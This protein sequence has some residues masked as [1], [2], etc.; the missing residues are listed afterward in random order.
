MTDLIRG[1]VLVLAVAGCA[2]DP[3]VGTVSGE[4]TLDGQPLK[5][6]IIKFIPGDGKT[7]TADAPVRDGRYS[8]TVPPGPK[9]VEVSAP[10]VVGKRK[11]YDTP[12][13]PEVDV[14]SE[15]IPAR[16]NVQSELTMTVAAGRQTMNY[17]LKSR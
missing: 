12:G 15:L 8:A 1:V 4:V 10:K 2:T 9:R 11:V 7:A 13:S 5:D 14:V 16:Y 3:S 6:G 17:E